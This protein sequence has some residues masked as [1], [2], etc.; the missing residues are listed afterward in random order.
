[1]PELDAMGFKRLG[2]DVQISRTAR[3]YTPEHI[4]VGALSIMGDFAFLPEYVELGRH[5]I[6]GA[7]SAEFAN[8]VMSG[9]VR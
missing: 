2:T 1:M 6:V 4:S 9:G 8:V 7:N 3:L 5:V